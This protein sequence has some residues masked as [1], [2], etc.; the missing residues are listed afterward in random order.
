MPL[1]PGRD[2]ARR[3]LGVRHQVDQIVDRVRDAGHRVGGHHV[4]QPHHQ[5][6]TVGGHHRLEAEVTD[7][8]RPGR[9]RR[10]AGRVEVDGDRRGQG[11]GRGHLH[12][13]R[14]AVELHEAR[15]LPV[16]RHHRQVVAVGAGVIGARVRVLDRIGH[17][18]RVADRAVVGGVEGTGAVGCVRAGVEAGIGERGAAREEPANAGRRLVPRRGQGL[19]SVQPELHR[20]ADLLQAERDPPVDAGPV[21]RDGRVDEG[22]AL[23]QVDVAGDRRHLRHRC[24]HQR[25]IGFGD[26]GLGPAGSDQQEPWRDA[27]HRSPPWS[28]GCAADG[29]PRAPFWAASRDLEVPW[30]PARVGPRATGAATAAARGAPCAWPGSGSPTGSCG[31]CRASVGARPDRGRPSR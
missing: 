1:V 17:R 13:D 29:R 23:H 2:I 25:V 24:E 28:T 26:T 21:R 10:R 8:R 16:G 5:E 22:V 14:L 11:L 18:P 3:R 15:R 27:F 4:A 12:A 6:A 20:A 30:G 19:G 7:E 31:T 9:D